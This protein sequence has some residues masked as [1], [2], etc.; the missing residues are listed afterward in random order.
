[1]SLTPAAAETLRQ[2]LATVVVV[3]VTP[4]QADGHPD[5][6]AYAALTRRLIDGGITVITPNGNTGEFYALS[7]AEAR[8]V[9]ET[10]AAA[11]NGQAELLA[12]VGHDIATAVEAAGHARDH[13]ARMI[14]IH[15]P[16]HP[17]VS[18]EGWIDYH[19]A[20]ASN[21][22][23]L[24]IV[25]YLRNER[26]TGADIAALA[27]RAPN[28]VGVK[29]G[30]RDAGTFA[31][32]ARDAGIDRFTWLA[33][34][35]ELTAP[36]YW[37]CGA[38]GFTSGL[39]NVT[40][41][42]P[43]A[44]LDALRAGDFAPG[45]EGLGKDTPVRGTP[46]GRRERRQRERGQGGAGP[47]R[48]VPRRCPPAEPPAATARQ[49][50]DQRHPDRL[51]PGM[52]KKP[53]ELRSYR[54]FG[55]ER[56]SGL[57]SFSHRSRMR[58]LGVDGEEHLGKPLIAILNTW[59]ELNPCHMHLRQRAEQ[60]KR[61]V[62]EAG[63]F[64]VEMP[65]ATLSETFQKPTPMMYR[66]LLAMEAEE[67]LR[68]YPADGAVL[69]GGCDK[70]TPALL[71]GAASANIPAIYVTAGPMLRGNYRG[72][73][74]GSGTDLW[75]FWDDARAGLIGECELAELEC[76]IARS[77]GH[78]MTMGTASTMT[79]AAEALGMTLPGM[80]SIPAV[81]SAHYRMA[82]AS[83]RRIVAMAWEDLT[84]DKILT[85]EAFE[86]AV[87]TVLALGGSTNAFIH[88]I[89]MAGRAGVDLTLDDF[90]AISRRV[91]W[92]AN[93]RPSGKYLMEDFYFAG[94][95]PALLGQ[96]AKVPGALHPDR[97]TVTGRP[98]GEQYR[99]GTRPQ[100]RRHPRARHRAGRRGRGGGAARQPGPGRRGHQ[101]HR[102]R[103]AADQAHRPRRRLRL[104]LRA[105]RTHQ[106]P[107][108]E[109]HPRL[110]PGAAQRR[111]PRAAPACPST[112]C[113]PSPATCSSRAS[114]T[115]CGSPTPG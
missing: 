32:V 14:M 20:I 101:A 86:D 48:P 112:A 84:P 100:P 110:G 6:A 114:A 93:I 70:T 89:A 49:R 18:R 64:P 47:A 79:S 95:L 23:D 115:W 72:Q 102:G 52:T 71:M 3:P 60:V 36:A 33:G 10:A 113:C 73:P 90:D 24:G 27:D 53:E 74:L 94:G 59:S 12:G 88:L 19:A 96:L 104:L 97:M 76:G 107:G 111:A 51:G 55:G 35:A 44:M 40:P 2:A 4:L 13:G 39:A 50:R 62:L 61:G 108:A 82:A 30:V 56:T 63:G 21:V 11:S 87:A 91:P 16:V 65:V 25:L 22:P 15:Q 8:Q 57:R 106:R 92:L 7:Q 58:Q 46:R 68:S 31:A 98:F 69:M 26:I 5:W 80:A 9:V 77:P 105:A 41:E 83:G 67:L 29:Y 109:H 78:C 54:W 103:T 1:M 45:D 38:H 43:L 42:L 85:R 17:Y 66:N 99:R 37:A 75:K 34:A 28:V 81:D